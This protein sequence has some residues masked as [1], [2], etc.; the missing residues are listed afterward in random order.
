MTEA[1]F[2]FAVS[3]EHDINALAAFTIKLHN[4]T[5]QIA[6]DIAIGITQ[7]S[8]PKGDLSLSDGETYTISIAPPPDPV[9][10]FGSESVP[11]QSYVVGAAIDDLPLPAATGGDGALTYSLMPDV[12]TTGLSFDSATRTVSGTATTSQAATDYT[13]TATDSDATNPDS[14]TLSFSVEIAPAKAPAP[15]PTVGNGQVTLN[16]A[17]PADA[18]ISGWELKRDSGRMGRDLAD[19]NRDVEPRR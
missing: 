4:S 2:R 6:D 16:W 18:G 1:D 17:K 13:W 11:D 8:W 14:D 7:S 12:T 10:D 3:Q 9:P 15:T 19:R 5:F